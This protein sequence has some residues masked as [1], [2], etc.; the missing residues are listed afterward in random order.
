MK[1]L[2]YL[3]SFVLLFISSLHALTL[4][5]MK[6][7]IREQIDDRSDPRHRYSDTALIYMLNEAQRDMVNKSWCL[8]ETY[9]TTLS[10]RT[11]YYNLPTD[12]V[13]V[14][15]FNFVESNGR[16][17]Q[18]EE[19]SERVLYQS[20]PDYARQSGQ[21]MYYFTRFSTTTATQL[22]FGL[23]PVPAT[24]SSTGTIYLKYY[25][26]AT[27]LSSNSDIPLGGFRH[28]YPYHS[29]LVHYAIWKFKLLMGDP[30]GATVYLAMYEN[31]V[32][33]MISLLGMRPN[34]SPSLSAGGSG[35]SSP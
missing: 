15:E 35:R 1:K 11:T 19:K 21:P 23:N 5:D 17:R 13:A 6:I 24:A 3:A 32:K 18:L 10:L 2:I 7:Q 30:Q 4:K 31:E 34:Y 20:N 26:Q 33:T 16:T 8:E 28:L 9:S 27:D 14:K 12:F 22:E 25:A 29:A